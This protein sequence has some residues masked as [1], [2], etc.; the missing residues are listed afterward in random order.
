[1]KLTIFNSQ[2]IL[3]TTTIDSIKNILIPIFNHLTMDKRQIINRYPLIIK[4]HLINL[5]LISVL[6]ISKEINS[7]IHHMAISLKQIVFKN[8]IIQNLM[9]ILELLF[10]QILSTEIQIL[11]LLIIKII[12][13][14]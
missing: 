3:I 12:Q 4:V 11:N 9:I 6:H 8:Q 13:L 5:T 14:M 1:M 2:D 10:I 7:T